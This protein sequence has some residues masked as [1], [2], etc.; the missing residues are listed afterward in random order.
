M[1]IT[2]FITLPKGLG[3]LKLAS[4]ISVISLVDVAQAWKKFKAVFPLAQFAYST[5]RISVIEFV[6]TFLVAD[7][8]VKLI[9]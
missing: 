9:L 4:L 3:T 7:F 8:P 5:F 6:D 2:A 1:E